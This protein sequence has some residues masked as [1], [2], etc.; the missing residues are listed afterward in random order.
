MRVLQKRVRGRK[1]ALHYVPVVPSPRRT[2]VGMF[3]ERVGLCP[4]S[5]LANLALFFNERLEV[6]EAQCGT[7]HRL[8]YCDAK[9]SV[10]HIG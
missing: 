7:N 3:F 10:P 5:C 1:C 6:C 2:W 9:E 8:S 4:P